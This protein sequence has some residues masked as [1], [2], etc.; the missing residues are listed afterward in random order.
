MGECL[1][2]GRVQILS[3]SQARA[4]GLIHPYR[5]VEPAKPELEQP[6][7]V[8]GPSWA[9]TKPQA[10]LITRSV[11]KTKIM[12]NSPMFSKNA[13]DLIVFHPA[14]LSF[15]I[16][17]KILLTLQ[18]ASGTVNYLHY[19]IVDWHFRKYYVLIKCMELTC[20]FGISH[21]TNKFFGPKNM[22][23]ND[24]LSENWAGKN[25]SYFSKQR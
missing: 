23:F 13:S 22:L 6:F 4:W 8:S 1:V 11:R 7:Q 3:S 10:R 14:S 15:E 5:W 9:K 18:Q 16:L 12:Q 17:E 24:P 19:K 20:F 2:M 21:I 25:C